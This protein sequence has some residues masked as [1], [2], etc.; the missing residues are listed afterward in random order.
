MPNSKPIQRI[1]I[2]SKKISSE[3]IISNEKSFDLLEFLTTKPAEGSNCPL[4]GSLLFARKSPIAFSLTLMAIL[5][6]I[7]LINPIHFFYK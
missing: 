1:E 3:E 7:Y 2:P 4:R 5:S 6:L